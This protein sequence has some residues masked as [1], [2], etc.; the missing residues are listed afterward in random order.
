MTARGQYVSPSFLAARRLWSFFFLPS[1]R[2]RAGASFVKPFSR[3]SFVHRRQTKLYPYRFSNLSQNFILL[4]TP[5]VRG[6]LLLLCCRICL[7]IV[8]YYCLSSGVRF[9]K[10]GSFFFVYYGTRNNTSATCR[11]NR[12]IFATDSIVSIDIDNHVRRFK[13]I[14]LLSFARFKNIA[15]TA[16]RDGGKNH[17]ARFFS[18]IDLRTT[19]VCFPSF[20]CLICFL[21]F[22]PPVSPNLS[23]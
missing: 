4:S 19:T 11:I 6:S 15:K 13:R 1:P 12:K 18:G 16:N 2:T 14:L 10:I 20:S 23:Q 5:T 7:K 8:Q 17:W 22:P 3:F 21:F 9:G